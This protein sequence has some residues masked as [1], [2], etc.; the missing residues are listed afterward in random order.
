MAGISG[1]GKLRQWLID[2]VDGG[3]YPGL[4][5]ED[6]EKS[7]FRIPWKHAG[8][9]DYNREEDAALFKAWALFKGKYREGIDKPDPPT[10]KTRLRCA[11]N[12]SNDF[13]EL[14][15]RS[16]LDTSEPYKVYRVIPEG[17]KRVSCERTS[18]MTSPHSFPLYPA[19]TSLQSQVPNFLSPV[20]KGWRDLPEQAAFPDFYYPYSPNSY[21]ASWDPVGYQIN[22]SFYSCGGFDPSSSSFNYEQSMRSAAFSDP[23]LQVSVFSGDSLIREVT[24]SSTEGCRLALYEENQNYGGPELVQLPQCE[25][26]ELEHGVLIWMAPD[27]LCA[28][29]LCNARVYWEPA[30]NTNA[31]K[32]NKLERNQTSKLLDIHQFMAELQGYYLQARPPPSFQVLLYF[33]QCHDIQAHRRPLTVQVEP[34]FARQLFILS[35]QGSTHHMRAPDTSP[36]MWEQM[37]PSQQNIYTGSSHQHDT[38]QD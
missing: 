21:A 4:V 13:E 38:L 23:R 26:T 10:W 24:V 35:Q 32:P 37:P 27:G 28:R 25:G 8:K 33:E 16:Q 36:L 29:R 5:W 31:D 14:V 22:N 20:E 18:T 1:N 34:L 2:Q 9:Q 17:T 19:Y 30:P 15:E 6:R 3:K 7:T 12:K 11:L